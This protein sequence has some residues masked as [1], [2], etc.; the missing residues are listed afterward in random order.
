MPQTDRELMLRFVGGDES[1]FV[2]LLTKFKPQLLDFAQQIVRNRETAEDVVQE[3][4]LR[5]LRAKSTYRPVAEFSTWIYT[6]ATNLCYDELRKR[7]RQVSFESMLGR[8]PRPGESAVWPGAIRRSSSPQPDLQL[9][10]KE[11]GRLVKDVVQELSDEHREVI[12]LRMDQ[13]LGYAEAAKR[14]GCSAGTVK[15]RMH[16]A[17][18]NLR[19]AL[20]KRM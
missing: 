5:V 17:M 9:E 14:L 4:F 19:E 12:S 20:M 8:P 10:R 15:S 11:L 2:E 6:I 13:G 18:R 3:T 16:Y 1:A 7:K